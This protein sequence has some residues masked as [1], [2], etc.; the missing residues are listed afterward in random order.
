MYDV[1]TSD[2]CA[3]LTS[4]STKCA[5]IRTMHT[6]SSLCSGDIR[7]AFGISSVDRVHVMYS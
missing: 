2:V 4:Y 3:L 6:M 5:A 1:C 7:V